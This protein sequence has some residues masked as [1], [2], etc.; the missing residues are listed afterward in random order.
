MISSWG[1]LLAALVL[2][3]PG[4]A[5]TTAVSS[6]PLRAD[7]ATPSDLAPPFERPNGMLLRPMTAT[8][9]LSLTHAG[10]V[11]ALGSRTV[12]VSETTLGGSPAW[13]IAEARVGSAV[14]TRDSVVVAR[15]DLTP[16]RWSAAVGTATMAASLTRDSLF[17]AMQTYQGRTSVIAALPAGS[18]LT[19]GMVE[20]IVPLLPLRDG[21]RAGA[22]LV[23]VEMTAPRV[24]PALLS[25]ERR[26]SCAVLGQLEECWLVFLRGGGVEER[27]WVTRTNARVVRT[28]Q[29][30]AA[31]VLTS[32]LSQASG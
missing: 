28:E 12:H 18:L 31:G 29:G 32:V 10:G 22:A 7:S 25:V 16:V 13:L 19:P 30:T 1:A 20:Q 21:Y 8:F 27:L 11:T 15:A 24:I 3:Q 6:I 4:L 9:E 23:L 2:S 17:G 14:A 26:E 5:Q